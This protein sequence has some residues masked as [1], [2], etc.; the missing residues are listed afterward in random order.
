MHAADLGESDAIEIDVISSCA[1]DED[2]I[3][4]RTLRV[5]DEQSN[6]IL[7]DS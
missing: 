1:K 6:F 7:H 5:K 4:R 2:R 3:I